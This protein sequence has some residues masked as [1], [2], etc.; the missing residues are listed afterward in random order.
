MDND[1]YYEPNLYE[2][3]KENKN[4]A[5]FFLPIKQLALF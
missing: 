4:K 1:V 5:P 3:V 2:C